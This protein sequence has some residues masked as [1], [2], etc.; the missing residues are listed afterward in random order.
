M[1]QR[2]LSSIGPPLYSDADVLAVSKPEG[3]ATIPERRPTGGSL[4]ESLGHGLGMRL[5]VVHRLDKAASGVVV[6]AKNAAA[7]RCLNDQFA[8]RQVDKTYLV[9]VHGRVAEDA[10]EIDL[11]LRQ[12]GSGRMGVDRRRGKPSLS[13]FRVL[14]RCDA[15]TLLSVALITGRRHQIRVHLYAAGHPI[16]GDV[17]YGDIGRQRAF[18]R[19]MLH[20]CRIGFR[21][22]S[23]GP[24]TIRALPPATF[25]KLL[26]QICPGAGDL[27][28]DGG[29]C[30]EA[31]TPNLGEGGGR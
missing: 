13:R 25:A 1:S 10:G 14:W 18:A 9:L 31:G 11:P 5:F 30:L 19:L 4:V 7:H 12:F 8:A 21:L 20:A 26:A 16:V 24:C 29:R 22:P 23:G 15:A 3:M 2:R 17:R 27:D 28:I 6:L